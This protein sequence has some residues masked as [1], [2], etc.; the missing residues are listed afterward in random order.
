MLTQ[1]VESASALRR[2]PA[3]I[4]LT[5]LVGLGA[6]HA[7]TL[8]ISGAGFVRHCPCDFDLAADTALVNNGVL[9]PQATNTHY[10]ASVVFPRDGERVCGF[11]L[12]YRDV[13]AKDAMTVRL[14]RKVA[15]TNGDAAVPPVEMATV[16]SAHGTPD[17]I[18][19]ASTRRIKSPEINTA[20][21]FY[22]V[23]AEVPT[24]NLEIIGVRI[25]VAPSCG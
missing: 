8:Q 11:T 10:F 17:T 4:A 18:R 19:I 2:A 25:E 16:K 9:Q 12:V 22:F 21:S 15:K 7:D 14:L 20:N 1:V 6:A 23:E 24:V 3:V 5:V 13:N